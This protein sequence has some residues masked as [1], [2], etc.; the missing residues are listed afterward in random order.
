MQIDSKFLARHLD[1]NRWASERVLESC[2]VLTEEELTT[3]L[4]NSHGGIFSTLQ[5][6]FLSDRVWLSRLVGSPRTTFNDPGESWNIITL[7]PAWGAVHGQFSTWVRGLADTGALLEY[8]RMDGSVH[9]QP[10]WEIV[11]HVVNH[12]S[13]HRGQITTMLRQLG[14]VPANTD[15]H[16]YFLSH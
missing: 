4:K 3:D 14:Q 13:Y 12:A 16:L 2:A 1:Y 5:H 6:I 10:V 7:G 11:L 8:R 9:T 15:L